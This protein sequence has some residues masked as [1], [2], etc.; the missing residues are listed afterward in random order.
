M[1]FVDCRSGARACRH[2]TDSWRCF[3][4]FL[5]SLVSLSIYRLTALADWIVGVLPSELKLIENIAIRILYIPEIGQRT[6]GQIGLEWFTHKIQP[7]D[8]LLK[9]QFYGLK[10]IDC[11]RFKIQQK[12]TDTLKK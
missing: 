4:I 7:M 12:S 9:L 3:F 5:R 6:N 10:K 8:T 11:V 1:H 2:V